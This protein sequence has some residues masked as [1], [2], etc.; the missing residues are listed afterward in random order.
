[1]CEME[2]ARCKA[3]GRSL[4][5]FPFFVYAFPLPNSPPKNAL[6]WLH[7]YVGSNYNAAL[8]KVLIALPSGGVEDQTVFLYGLSASLHLE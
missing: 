8:E 7:S 3:S 5:C 2:P 1:M 6:L 4:S